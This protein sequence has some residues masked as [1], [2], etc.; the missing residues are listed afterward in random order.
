[1]RPRVPLP[2]LL[3]VAPP[4]SARR[5]V[6]PGTRRDSRAQQMPSPLQTSMLCSRMAC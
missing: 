4:P 1:M 5:P 6:V 3:R 2:L